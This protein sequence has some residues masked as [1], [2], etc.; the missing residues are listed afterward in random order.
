MSTET[1]ATQAKQH[2]WKRFLIPDS[3]FRI[4]AFPY[5]R[6]KLTTFK[7]ADTLMTFAR[8]FCYRRKRQ[9]DS[10]YNVIQ[11]EVSFYIRGTRKLACHSCHAITTQF[12]DLL[13]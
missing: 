2:T 9:A 11:I 5:A 10:R 3:G 12:V 13:F 7:T 4:P 6:G 1:L 8:D